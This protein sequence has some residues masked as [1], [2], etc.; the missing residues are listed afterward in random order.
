MS[1]EKSVFSLVDFSRQHRRPAL[2]G[3]HPAH[4]PAMGRADFGLAGAGRKA[5]DLI[6]LLLCHAARARRASRPLTSVRMDVVTPGGHTA[7]E[8]SFE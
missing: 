7:V 6:G 8:I 5:K 3:V 4:Q 2:V 1:A